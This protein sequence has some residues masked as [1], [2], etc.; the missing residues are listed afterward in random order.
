MA[1]GERRCLKDPWAGGALKEGRCETRH[2]LAVN[3]ERPTAGHGASVA[4]LY[5][6]GNRGRAP[7]SG[8]LQ[9]DNCT[10]C[11]PDEK[12]SVNL[13]FLKSTLPGLR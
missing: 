4:W 7:A 5:H 2:K 12:T 1:S 3:Y 13:S 11:M 6:E 10:S 9:A 8:A